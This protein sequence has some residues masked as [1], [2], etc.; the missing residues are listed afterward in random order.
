[1]YATKWIPE[2]PDP[3]RRQQMTWILAGS[4]LLGILIVGGGV[5]YLRKEKCI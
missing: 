4:A 2:E 3:A 1:M 5:Y